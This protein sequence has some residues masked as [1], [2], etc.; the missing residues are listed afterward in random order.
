MSAN[1]SGRKSFDLT[2]ASLSVNGQ[3]KSLLSET[4]RLMRRH[5]LRA[6]KGLAQHFL[7]DGV[8][9]QRILDAAELAPSDV[10]LEVGP[11]MGVLTEQLAQRAGWVI[12]VE[13]DDTLA[14]MLKQRL[15]SSYHNL[16]VVKGDILK[17]DPAALI[18]ERK[19][20]LPPGVD[21]TSYKVVANLP[22]YITSPT[23]RLFLEASVKPEIMVVMVQ[24]EVAEEIAAKPGRMS[25][26]SISVQLYGEPEVVAT[27]PAQSFYPAPEVDSAI[28]KIRLFDKPTVAVDTK[29][30]FHVVRAG[31]SAARKQLG[32]SLAQGLE[33]DK[34][35]ALTLLE[36]AGIDSQRRAET[37]TLEE[38]A[39]LW[40][41]ISGADL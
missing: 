37:L 14:A 35:E 18:E 8:A 2:S 10:V 41:I 12:T 11:G 3:D 16:T 24:K 31:F 34:A 25:V 19:S 36:K 15:V 26:L 23:L 27:V 9:L 22:Y 38:W 21:S 6:R 30:F 17:I 7:V 13:L 32:N 33:L 4:M 40:R 1:R 5:G 28:L 39:R 29:G 20:E